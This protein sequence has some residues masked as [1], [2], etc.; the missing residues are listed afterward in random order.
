MVLEVRI[1]NKNENHDIDVDNNITAYE[2]VN[3]LNIAF[4]LGIDTDDIS[5]CYI[6]TENPICLLRGDKKI[7]DFGIHEGTIINIL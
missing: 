5:Q 7:I 4:Q 6:R 3:A 2:L 1:L